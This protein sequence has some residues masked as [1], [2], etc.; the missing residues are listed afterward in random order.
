M[1][2]YT[3]LGSELDLFAKALNWKSYWRNHLR[4]FV[5]GTV[6]EVGAGNG[7]NTRA[8]QDLDCDHW[9]CIEPD[10][11]LCAQMR[12]NTALGPRAQVIVGTL[13]DLP[14]EPPADTILYLDV[15]EHIEDDASELRL[16]ARHLRPG[17]HLIVLAPAH[18][19]LYSPFDGAVGHFRRYCRRSLC[20]AAPAELSLL[21][22]RYLDS[23]GLIASVGNRLFL[24]HAMPT[25]KQLKVWDEY[26][27]PISRFIDPSLR[28]RLGKSILGVWRK[29]I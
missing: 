2:D 8:L 5:R 26:L 10:P 19:S 17:G 12:A 15:L 28:Y 6:L 18:Q 11:S 16:A 23:V 20:A 9:V 7:N 24:K 29:T 14:E 22:V 1:S 4:A 3:Y 13:A 27:V 21:L 25:A